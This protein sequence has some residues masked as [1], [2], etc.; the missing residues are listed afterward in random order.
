MLW[1]NNLGLRIKSLYQSLNLIHLFLISEV[2]LAENNHICEFNLIN[3][4]L[5]QLNFLLLFNIAFGDS[6]NDFLNRF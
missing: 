3:Q 2:S 6:L 5:A 1:E 4:E